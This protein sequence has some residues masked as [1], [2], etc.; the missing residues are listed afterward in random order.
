MPF[1]GGWDWIGLRLARRTGTMTSG[2][3][4]GGGSGGGS[5]AAPLYSPVTGKGKRL[6]PRAGACLKASTDLATMTV[7]LDHERYP[8]AWCG[9]FIITR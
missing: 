1:G 9:A 8:M 5:D 6:D 3:I 2:T 7:T 4:R